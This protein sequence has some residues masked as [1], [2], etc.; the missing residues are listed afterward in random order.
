MLTRHLRY[1]TA[2]TVH[3]LNLA[4]PGLKT[5]AHLQPPI[6]IANTTN[7]RRPTYLLKNTN[8]ACRIYLPSVKH[9]SLLQRHSEFEMTPSVSMNFIS[10]VTSC[11]RLR[12]KGAKHSLSHALYRGIS[13]GCQRAHGMLK[14]TYVR[15]IATAMG[16]MI[17]EVEL[18][19]HPWHKYKKPSYDMT[20]FFHRPGSI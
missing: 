14:F 12:E 13:Y 19:Q 18:K 8:D 10:L 6:S 20:S 4:M 15:R 9:Q 16:C 11:L 2:R 17:R 1:F 3:I 7:W 5:H